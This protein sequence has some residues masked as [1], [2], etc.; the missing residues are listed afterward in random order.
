MDIIT[1]NE[2]SFSTTD[3]SD[4]PGIAAADD[5]NDE[6]VADLFAE[7]LDQPRRKYE[8]SGKCS[9][10]YLDSV[11]IEFESLNEDFL[12]LGGTLSVIQITCLDV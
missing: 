1:S 2:E 8:R 5:D 6:E 10:G 11:E 12:V 7:V 9:F 4:A 3:G